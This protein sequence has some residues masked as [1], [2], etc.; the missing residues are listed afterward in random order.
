MTDDELLA[1]ECPDG[2]LT[3]PGHARCP[4]CGAEQTGTLDL[5]DRT[6]EVVT[7][8]TVGASPTGVR[9]PNPLAIVEFGVQERTVRVIGGTTHDVEVGDTVEPVF[10]EQ[11][12]DPAVSIRATESQSWSGYR[13]EPVDG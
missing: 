12:R 4:E 3:Y 13:F 11:L 6:G 2:H 7:W 9:E 5:S 8:T 10:V 1:H